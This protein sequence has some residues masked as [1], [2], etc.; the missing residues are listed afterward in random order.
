MADT[1]LI[2]SLAVE[3]VIGDYEWERHIL[4]RL[5]IDL[6]MAWDNQAPGASDNVSDALDY[7]AVSALVRDWFK[8]NQ[9]RLLEAAAESLAA[10]IRTEFGVAWLRLTLRKPGAVPDARSVGVRI[11][12]GVC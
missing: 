5:E 2:E 9:P 12:R 7:A 6:E 8:A 3:T 10:L 1:V 11:E 4:Q